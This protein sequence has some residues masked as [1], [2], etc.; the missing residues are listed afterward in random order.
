[1]TT[2][3]F[4][5]G[6]W[7]MSPVVTQAAGSASPVPVS[8]AIGLVG[9]SLVNHNVPQ[10]LRTIA[11]D[12][13]KTPLVYEQII[14]GSPL[15]H[16]WKN[17]D[18]AEVVEGVYGNLHVAISKA[19]PAFTDVILTER[20]AIAECIKWE[21]TLGNVIRWRNHALA[22]NPQAQVYMYSTWV[23]FAEG[24]WWKDIPDDATWRART[25]AD[26]QLFAD[27]A[28]QATADARSTKGKPV[29]M[30]PGHKALV[31][32]HDALA[33]G[34]LPWLGTNIRAAFSDNIHLNSTGNYLIACVMY[35]SVFKASPVGATGVT[36]DIWGRPLTN[37][38]PAQA[39]DLQEIAWKAVRP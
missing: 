19:S 18:K 37:L 30:V 10:M 9:H 17:A 16:N 38:T 15:S 13:G 26:G 8:P 20:V 14:N 21:D 28:A 4:L 22:F 39:R 35:A 27:I 31:L 32:L 12:Q 11:A 3:F 33:A 6:F 1:V 2:A 25:L 29:L 7:A 24:E 5:T 23:G 36:A 34:K